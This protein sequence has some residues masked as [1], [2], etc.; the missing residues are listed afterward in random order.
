MGRNLLAALQVYDPAVTPADLLRLEFEADEASEMP[1]VWVTAQTL[2]FIL[3]YQLMGRVVNL[4]V[5]RTG[6]V[7]Q[8]QNNIYKWPCRKD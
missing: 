1:I 3:G 6:T 2:L 8:N 4:M 5:T 7:T